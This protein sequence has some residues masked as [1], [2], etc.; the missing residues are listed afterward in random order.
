MTRSPHCDVGHAGS[1]GPVV[2]GPTL[3]GVTLHTRN[4]NAPPLE[5]MTRVPTGNGVSCVHT[6]APTAPLPVA[7][8]A[9]VQVRPSSNKVKL[10]QERW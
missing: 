9:F 1:V 8:P 2:H 7:L 5:G 6:T 4:T 3:F 10:L